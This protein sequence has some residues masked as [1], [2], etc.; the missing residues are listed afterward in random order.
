MEGPSEPLVINLSSKHLQSEEMSILSRGLKFC[1]TPQNF[2][3]NERN[4]NNNNFCRR[5]KCFEFFKDSDVT[6]ASLLAPLSFWEPASSG[7]EKLEEPERTIFNIRINDIFGKPFD[8]GYLKQKRLIV[9]VNVA[10]K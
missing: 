7:N 5:L 10:C 6:R 2:K 1:P 4:E 8:L 3:I 9:V